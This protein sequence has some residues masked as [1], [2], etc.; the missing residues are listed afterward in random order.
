MQIRVNTDR[1]IE[2]HGNLAAYVSST[3]ESALGRFSDSLTRVEVHL[4]EQS[5]GRKGSNHDMRCLIEA[6]L[7]GRQPIAV[8]HH[9]ASIG[10]TVDGAAGKL[11]RKID[12]TL[13]RLRDEKSRA[14]K[15]LPALQEDET[16]E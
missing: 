3:V 12:H 6:R 2:G 5:G 16:P 13:A 15:P 8:T 4:S 14:A 1:N 7:E 11:S 9:A 10:Q